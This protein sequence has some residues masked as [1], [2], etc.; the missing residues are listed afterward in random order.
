MFGTFYTSVVPIISSKYTSNLQVIFR[1]QVQPWHP[2]S[3]LVHEAGVAVLKLAPNKFWSFSEA[4]FKDQVSFFDSNVV[5]E[6]RNKTYTRLAKVGESVGIDP[7]EMLHLLTVSDKP[8]PDGSQNNGNGV[9]N[10][11][12]FLIKVSNSQ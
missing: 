4:L 12:K 6:P 1:Q 5:N 2:S 11:L 10:D 9:T 8:G 7:N 3:T